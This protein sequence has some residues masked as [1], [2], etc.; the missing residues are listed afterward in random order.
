MAEF[1]IFERTI[2]RR[3]PNTDLFIKL[4]CDK[5]NEISRSTPLK[6]ELVEAF[7][8][9][10]PV[11]VLTIKDYR[12]DL[13][14]H[15]KVNTAGTFTLNFGRTLEESIDIQLKISKYEQMNSIMGRSHEMELKITFVMANWYPMMSVRHNRGWA[16]TKYSDIISELAGEG[17]YGEVNV[18]ESEGEVKSTIQPYWTNNKMLRWIK[19]KM[20]PS[21]EFTASEGY[22]HYE[23]GVTLENK[24]FYQIT[25]EIIK[26]TGEAAKMTLDMADKKGEEAAKNRKGNKSVPTYFLGVHNKEFYTSGIIRGGGGVTSKY[27]DWETDEIKTEEIAFASEDTPMLSDYSSIREDVTSNKE[28]FY[29]GTDVNTPF[30]AKNYV[31]E[32]AH[33]MF[34]LDI[35][36]EGS[37]FIHI[38]DVVELVIPATNL[39][40]KIPI[41]SMY[42]GF[43]IVSG[44]RH[45]FSFGDSTVDYVTE[46]SLTRHGVDHFDYEGF[47]DLVV[48]SKGKVV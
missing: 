14:N 38:F 40:S 8:M 28:Q 11:V 30:H 7:G 31:N 9:I 20:Y 44:V 47:D 43:Y 21:E 19:E 1:V 2:S 32:S 36:T 15:M 41:N 22:G 4:V 3:D 16:D 17:S 26:K 18:T 42:S 34:G 35:M 25:S 46:A 33:S 13:F 37:P 39:G 23:M 24:F 6:M 5:H 27:Y 10:S 45:S 29:G 12:G 48:S